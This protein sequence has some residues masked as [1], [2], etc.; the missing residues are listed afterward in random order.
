MRNSFSPQSEWLRNAVAVQVVSSIDEKV[1]VHHITETL[2][3]IQLEI[4]RRS[5]DKITFERIII[6]Y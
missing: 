1:I 4:E 2:N 6:N 3:F 5:C